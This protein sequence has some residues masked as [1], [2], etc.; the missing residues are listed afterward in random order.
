MSSESS[1]SSVPDLIP[2]N[3]SSDPSAPEEVEETEDMEDMFTVK[4]DLLTSTD[5]VAKPIAELPVE[6]AEKEKNV[7]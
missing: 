4:D 3:S 2:N 7:R 6:Q 1:I 5:E